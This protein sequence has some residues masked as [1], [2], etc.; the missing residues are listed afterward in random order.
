MASFEKVN[1]SLRPAKSVQQQLAIEGVRQ[2]LREIR[3]E[4]PIYIGLGSIWF[5]DFMAAHKQL[6]IEKMI[7]IENCGIGVARAKFNK[8]FSTVC[9]Q[10]GEAG[11]VLE[12][13]YEKDELNQSP[14]FVWLDYDSHLNEGILNVLKALTIKAPKNSILLTTFN[15]NRSRYGRLKS[16]VGQ[17]LERREKLKKLFGDAFPDE[18]TQQ[19]LKDEATLADLLANLTLDTLDNH[20]QEAGRSGG[21][22]KAFRMIYSDNARMVTVGGVLPANGHEA[23][24][25]EIVASDEWPCLPEDP[26]DL[27]PLTVLEILTLQARHPRE[28]PLTKENAQEELGFVLEDQQLKAFWRYYRYYP[29]FVRAA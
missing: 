3:P 11:E 6:G 27:P 2:I 12:K 19:V 10:E 8:P 15:C 21:F 28:T 23:R 20:V 24:V 25:R 18:V 16:E 1:Y 5:T 29:V 26:I 4:N 9:V 14:W 17:T 7:S 13:L 22:R